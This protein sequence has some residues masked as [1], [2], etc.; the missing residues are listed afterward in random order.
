MVSRCVPSCTERRRCREVRCGEGVIDEGC[1]DA[2]G[3]GRGSRKGQRSGSSVARPPAYRAPTPIHRPFLTHPP[4][5]TSHPPRFY[6]RRRRPRNRVAPTSRC[7]SSLGARTHCLKQLEDHVTSQK[8]APIQDYIEP[9]PRM[10]Q[11]KA[12]GENAHGRENDLAATTTTATRH[13][14]YRLARA[15]TWGDFGPYVLSARSGAGDLGRGGDSSVMAACGGGTT[16]GGSVCR[17]VGL[18]RAWAKA[19]GSEF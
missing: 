4:P 6:P 17:C 2:V 9:T 15:Q 7:T 8:S 14:S 11:T 1:S 16:F 18:W 19:P 13:R 3:R 12:G 10:H 5:F